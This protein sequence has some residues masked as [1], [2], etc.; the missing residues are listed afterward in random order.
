MINRA[1]CL[2]LL[3]ASVSVLFR[4]AVARDATWVEVKSPH[5]SVITD[6]GEKRG[7][8]VAIR[9]EQMRA[10]FANLMVQAKVN[11]PVPL[12]IVAFRN[13]KE[14]REV[15][16]LWKGKPVELAGL[17][18]G[19]S[20]R[21]FIMLDMSTDNPWSVVFHEYAH[22]LMNGTVTAPLDTW[23]E[24]GFAEYF[25]SI[26][27]D[28]H[29]ARVGK[30][31]DT[32]FEIVRRDGMMK[33][34]DLF[35]VQHNSAAYNESGDRRTVFYAESS[36][37]VH[38]LYDHNLIPKLVQYF[39]LKYNK[40]ASVEEAIQQSFGMSARDFDKAI[41]SYVAAGQYKYYFMKTPPEIETTGYATAPLTTTDAAAVVADI[42]AHSQDYHEKAF[43]E[44]EEI[45]KSDPN[46]ATACR[47]LGY[48][49][50]QK[51]DFENASEYFQRAAKV[52]SKDPYVHY[53]TGVLANMRGVQSD[54]K[55]VS[56]ELNKAI[57]LNPDFADAYMQL[58]WVQGRTGDL[59]AAVAS[60]RK[61]ISLNPRNQ[62]YYFNL[63]DLYMQQRKT[64]DA[65]GIFQTLTK[66]SNQMIALRAQAA[67]SQIE[68]MQARLKEFNQDSGP[69]LIRSENN[70]PVAPVEASTVPSI[71]SESAAVAPATVP[72]KV[73]FLKG[74]IT[75]V[76]CSASPAATLKVV[77]GGRTW[78]MHVSDSHHVLVMGADAFSCAWNRQKVALNYVVKGDSAGYV[79]SIEIQ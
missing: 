73:S 79:V 8:E 41:V 2:S 59:D 3:L 35:R 17:F 52:D 64:Q 34:S 5:F 19:G 75:S 56:D 38:Y 15:S 47:G 63:A 13:T 37:V 18:Q 20:D 25:S 77:S 39:D 27:V 49:Y 23:F 55:F 1:V 12:Q 70:A 46:N 24:E 67:A 22:Q 74:T 44:F 43:G 33:I 62:G 31:P 53:Y 66:S 28:S 42:H 26:E 30:I 29:Q 9:F 40:N 16:P 58:A 54:P 76:D 71:H 4:P 45:L 57:A 69:H 50:L 68:N 48:A 7:R 72:P 6:A 65:L 14:L 60:A 11:L 10:V 78:N 21:C 51:R 61:A 32:T 36:M